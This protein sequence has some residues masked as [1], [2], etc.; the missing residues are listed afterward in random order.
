[1][2]DILKVA[3]QISQNISEE[4]KNEMINMV[5]GAMSALMTPQENGQVG[6]PKGLQELMGTMMQNLP[7]DPSQQ[8]PQPQQQPPQIKSILKPT[9][10]S[11]EG[12]TTIENNNTSKKITFCSDEEDLGF[13]ENEEEGQYI[14]PKTKDLNYTLNIKLKDLYKGKKKKIT[15]SRKNFKKNPETDRY[16]IFEEK[17]K[18]II[19]IKPGLKHGHEFRFEGQADNSPG[20]TPGDVIITL[21]E[22]DDDVYERGNNDLFM[23]KCISFSD[24]YEYEHVFTHLN[25]QTYRIKSNE[26]DILMKH[27][28]IR[29]VSNLGMP[30]VDTDKFGDLFIRFSPIFPEEMSKESIKLLKTI[31]P[32]HEKLP[33]EED[34][35]KLGEITDKSLDCLTEKEHEKLDE[36]QRD[37]ILDD[38]ITDSEDDYSD[39]D[40]EDEEE[41]SESE[42]D[43]DEEESEDDDDEEEDEII[44]EE[45]SDDGL[46][47]QEEPRRGDEEDDDAPKGGP[48][49]LESLRDGQDDDE[50]GEKIEKEIIEKVLKETEEKFKD[51]VKDKEKEKKT[52]KK[53][54]TT[55]KQ[56]AV[57]T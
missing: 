28:C 35:E 8:Q 9:T 16:E 55:K 29:K 22:D 25:G 44:S 41:E 40:E 27:N 48:K 38:D 13:Y 32:A 23:I 11:P 14:K 51:D 36:I 5:N 15:F 2:K 53:K 3:E 4:Q 20:H 17:Q 1:M 18:I 43:D 10:T 30:I 24:V 26:K 31:I 12:A 19:P 39:D 6:L 49:D 34:I 21:S 37:Y 7:V 47:D 45:V 56:K 46:S 50:L 52:P 42:E 54:A 33:T 57:N